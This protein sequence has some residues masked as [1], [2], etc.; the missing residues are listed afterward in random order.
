MYG[1]PKTLVDNKNLFYSM[2]QG[3][4]SFIQSCQTLD[5]LHI[6]FDQAKMFPFHPSALLHCFTD[7]GENLHGYGSRL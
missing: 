2:M 1:E 6:N 4:F 7:G 3:V 5:L